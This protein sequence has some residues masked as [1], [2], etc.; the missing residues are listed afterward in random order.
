MGVISDKLDAEWAEKKTDEDMFAVRAVIQDFYNYLTGAISRGSALYPTGDTTF[1]GFVQPIVADMV[2]LKNLFEG[3]ENYM[4][5]IT[6]RIDRPPE[7]P[8]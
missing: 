6:W 4:E 1:D 7:E 3:D 8:E 5:F 2:A